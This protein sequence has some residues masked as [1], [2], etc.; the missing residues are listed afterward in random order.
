[1]INDTYIV[2]PRYLIN[3][4]P[5]RY[6]AFKTKIKGKYLDRCLPT[7]KTRKNIGLGTNI[8]HE[9]SISTTQP[10]CKFAKSNTHTHTDKEFIKT[11]IFKT[12]TC[13][14]G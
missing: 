12:L 11:L 3:T 13:P 10:K 4:L 14:L 9:S 6:L 5:F 8:M 7:L 2:L 1:M